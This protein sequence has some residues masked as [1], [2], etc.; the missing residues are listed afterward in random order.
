MRHSLHV[1]VQRKD[2]PLSWTHPEPLAKLGDDNPEVLADQ[3][4]LVEG[5]ESMDFPHVEPDLQRVCHQAPVVPQGSNDELPVHQRLPL[6]RDFPPP[7]YGPC[8]R[9]HLRVHP[10]V[11]PPLPPRLILG[12]PLPADH[13]PFVLPR[14][15]GPVPHHRPQ[16]VSSQ[17]RKDIGA[18]LSQ[19]LHDLVLWLPPGPLDTHH[20]HPVLP[21]FHHRSPHDSLQ[22]ALAPLHLARVL[23]PGQE[24]GGEKLPR[25]HRK[26]FP[27]PLLHSLH[28]HGGLVE[29]LVHPRVHGLG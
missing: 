5:A 2:A 6:E 12:L 26:H 4:Q 8:D 13:R 14:K 19:L 16:Q 25:D 22:E 18:L 9:F 3:Q 28:Q 10:V 23:L 11:L 1:V 27:A 21:S 24:A 20:L 17:Q 29:R 15:R 7:L